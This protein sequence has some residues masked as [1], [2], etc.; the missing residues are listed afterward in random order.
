M[1]RLND[2]HVHL[3]EK[4][5][6]DKRGRRSSA[7]FRGSVRVWRVHLIYVSICRVRFKWALFGFIFYHLEGGKVEFGIETKIYRIFHPVTELKFHV[8]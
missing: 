7:S 3:V 8:Y 1:D 5:L 2:G 6:C 4:T